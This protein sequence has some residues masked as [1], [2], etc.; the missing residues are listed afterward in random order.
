MLL[1]K[2]IDF[3]RFSLAYLFSHVMRFF[4]LGNNIWIITER[5]AECKDNGYHLF[6][7]IREHHPQQ[8]TFYAIDKQALDLKKVTDLGNV[9]YF[10]SF[11]H[12]LYSLLATR[13]IGAFNPVG[14]PNSFSF[15]KF[16]QLV[17]GKKVFLQHGITKELIQSLTYPSI[18]VDLF[19]CS[20]APEYKYVK[21][22]FGYAK[23][24]VQ[25]VGSCRYDNLNDFT[26]KKQILVMP[27]WRQ[28]LPS[29]TFKL[30]GEHQNVG[31][32]EE[33]LKSDYYAHYSSFLNN[34]EL[35][36]FLEREGYS[37]VFYLHHELQ[38]FTSL[39]KSS[40]KH[41]IMA[42]NKEHDV[43]VLLKESDLL[44]TDFSSVAFDFAYMDKPIIYYQFD[45]EE[46][47]K[48]HYARGYFDYRTMGFGPVVINENEL[49]ED[50]VKGFNYNRNKFDNKEKFFKRTND[51]FKLRDVLNCE[52]TYEAILNLSH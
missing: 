4:G 12:Y 39:F 25:Y 10:N 15:Y 49:I 19:C 20:A 16:P 32:E 14:I 48:S 35:I 46:Y 8:K 1:L 11:K 43:Q 9:I 22:F 27:T 50:L 24:A 29:Q 40:S 51:F 38:P 42:N 17:Q 34:K 26:V 45:E 37:L 3:S 13:L 52:R 31:V 7:Y 28:F 5:P 18:K 47:Y 6:K 36:S 30:K 2:I 44:I 23:D 21:E 41:I 33:F